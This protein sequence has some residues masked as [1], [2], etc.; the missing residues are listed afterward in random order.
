MQDNYKLTIAYKS[1]EN[2]AGLK[3]LGIDSNKLE[4]LLLRYKEQITFWECLVPF[5]SE[6]LSS[7]DP[8]KNFRF[9]T[10]ETDFISY[11]ACL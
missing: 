5:C 4:L 1:F 7:R 10:F 6:V 3:C 2:V 11:C 8:S 9:V